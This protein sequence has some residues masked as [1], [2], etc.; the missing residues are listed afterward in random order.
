VYRVQRRKNEETLLA[1]WSRQD[2]GFHRVSRAGVIEGLTDLPRK[3]LNLEVR[4]FGLVGGDQE[5]DETSADGRADAG[6]V[7]ALS[8]RHLALK[9]NYLVRF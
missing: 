6:L 9:V 3:G 7:W 5:E 2:G 1:G 8:Q 4:P